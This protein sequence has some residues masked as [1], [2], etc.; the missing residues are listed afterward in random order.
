M[1]KSKAEKQQIVCV[2][3][4]LILIYLGVNCLIAYFYY[5]DYHHSIDI[6]A[7]MLA[8]PDESRMNAAAHILKGNQWQAV[9]QGKQ[10]L[11]HYGYLNTDNNE[12][13]QYYLNR[14]FATAVLSF[15]LFVI[16]AILLFVWQKKVWRKQK[17][18]FIQVEETLVSFRES[19]MKVLFSEDDLEEQRRIKEQLEAL[20]NH[21]MFLREQARIEREG[22]KELVADISHQLKTPVAALDTCFSV[23]LRENL[24][25][26]E[27]KEF[28]A[29]CRNSLD[30]LETLLQSLLQISKMEAG[31]I[32]I[33]KCRVSLLDTIVLAVNRVYTKALEKQIELV[34]DYDEAL[35]SYA[36]MQ[37]RKW[38][39]EAIINVLD[40]AIKYSPAGSEVLVGLQ[41]GNGFARIKIVD[42]GF[43]IPKEEYH[44]IFQRFFRGS[45]PEVKEQNGSG[46]GL[47]LAR[48]IIEKHHGTITVSSSIEV[49]KSVNHRRGS[50]F[51]IQ[52]LEDE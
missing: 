13:Y 34:F 2:L 28:S 31:L 37:D 35:E 20:S 9:V 36:I 48:E 49:N 52:L 5:H 16:M 21:L 24:S 30:S 44:K 19:N 33:E 6:L 51:V 4:I 46:I 23:L 47:F 29:R 38:L 7:E 25:Q 18:I 15:F 45:V 1:R 42:Q 50:T 8:S 17:D 39:S 12:L 10:M 26:Q 3:F 14:C 11:M 43:G 22:T 32:Q 41:K 40:N 27:Q